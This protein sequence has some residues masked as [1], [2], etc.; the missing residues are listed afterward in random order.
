MKRIVKPSPAQPDSAA[1]ELSI[2]PL[3]HG[4]GLSLRLLEPDIRHG[5]FAIELDLTTLR[6]LSSDPEAY[7]AAL[8]D[9]LF[10]DPAA[11]RAFLACRAASLGAATRLRVRLLLPQELQALRWEAVLDPH[12]GRSLA[13]DGD[14]LLSRYLSGDDYT[15]IQ[16]RPKGQLRALVAVAAPSD[17]KDYGL[18]AINAGAEIARISAALGDLRPTA[19][20]ASWAQLSDALREGCD[21]LYLVAHGALVGG[22]P[23]L[24]LVDDLGNADR[25]RGE[26][27]ADLLRTLDAERRP[28]L[29]VLASCESAGDGYAGTLAAL[30]P[31][32]AR[33]GVPAVLA[34]Q[35]KLSAATNERFAPVFFSELLRHGV[36]DQAANSARLAVED[37]P[38]WWMPVLYN[39]LANGLLWPTSSTR[40]P[41]FAMSFATLITVVALL[42][43]VLAGAAYWLWPRP[44]T[45]MSEGSFNVAVAGIAIDAGDGTSY[46]DDPVGKALSDRIFLSLGK[47]DIEGLVGWQPYRGNGRQ[48]DTAQGI[49][50][51]AGTPTERANQA[52][53][54]AAELHA[55]IVIYGLIQLQVNEAGDAVYAPEIYVNPER[56]SAAIFG[57]E[58]VGVMQLGSF[59]TFNPSD[60]RGSAFEQ[61]TSRV[62]Q[63]SYFL[64]GLQEYRAQNFD[65]AREDFCRA[66]GGQ[67]PEGASPCDILNHPD[68]ITLPDQ[69]AA[70]VLVFLGALEGQVHSGDDSLALSLIAQAHHR[71]PTYARPFISKSTILY[72]QLLAILRGAVQPGAVANTGSPG[73]VRCFGEATALPT[74]PYGL[75]LQVRACL[76]E[77]LAAQDE[78]ELAEDEP[79]KDELAKNELAKDLMNVDVR[80]KVL[81]STA[82][83]YI[84]LTLI[85]DNPEE[86]WQAAKRILNELIG[87]YEQGDVAFRERFRRA[88][89]YAYAR[90]GLI[91]VYYPNMKAPAEKTPAEY[92]QAAHDYRTALHLLQTTDSCRADVAKCLDLD[93]A[94]IKEFRAELDRLHALHVGDSAPATR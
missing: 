74:D 6:A 63:L 3:G 18:A 85:T 73:A 48:R 53:R 5:P 9:I 54:I 24:Y 89:G 37:R 12:S 71:W 36:I 20:T 23:W 62:D 68:D 66:L 42:I 27:L 45:P 92:E 43:L 4:F 33:A 1:L 40:P 65:M 38:D 26:A 11:S 2:A 16:L 19:I 55:D 29:I 75:E 77:A 86:Y 49:G 88:A 87:L 46:G 52:A 83:F 14:L 76:Q 91:T 78:L 58:M 28:R 93:Q 13:R 94:A 60:T 34:M 39:R 50:F 21:I 10:A 32:L 41:A 81:L 90:R 70:V 82:T 67:P 25:R 79:A 84:T 31:L 35:G 57:E 22:Q 51:I 80:P 72:N 64:V 15:P 8:S 69:T 59:V 30:G 44:L 7:G 17:A 47:T 61:F 56:K